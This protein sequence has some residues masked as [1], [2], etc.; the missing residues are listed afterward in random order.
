MGFSALSAEEIARFAKDGFVIRNALLDEEEI[1]LLRDMACHDR[2][3][4]HRS[5][6]VQDGGGRKAR[7]AIWNHPGDDIY[8]AISRSRRIVEPME[9][10]LGGEV[11]HYHSKMILKEA[12]TGGA[13]EWHQDY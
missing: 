1:A 8:G 12:R 6:G 2:H 9:Q 10:L 7:L 5:F 11:Y 3:L 4:D 13:W